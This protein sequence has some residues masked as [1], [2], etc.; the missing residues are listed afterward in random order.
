VEKNKKKR[1]EMQTALL[2]KSGVFEKGHLPEGETGIT[3]C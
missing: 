2:L 3:V 1:R